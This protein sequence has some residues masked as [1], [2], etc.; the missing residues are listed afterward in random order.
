[1]TVSDPTLD[2]QLS[3]FL[4]DDLT[5]QE[6]HELEERLSTD[7]ELS[8][9]LES[10]RRL[11]L[12]IG[13]LAER[14]QPPAALDRLVA[15]RSL[16]START[17][18]RR[19][20]HALAAAATVVIAV[21]VGLQIA[22]RGG[23]GDHHDTA[24]QPRQA[25][26]PT[27]F[28][29]APLPE[30][31]DDGE[32]GPSARL[33]QTP[34]AQPQLDD[35]PALEPG[36][37]YDAPPT[38]EQRK[39]VATVD[40]PET[41]RKAHPSQEL[42][43]HASRLESIDPRAAD[44][45]DTPTTEGISQ[46]AAPR[47]AS[48]SRLRYAEEETTHDAPMATTEALSAVPQQLIRIQSVEL[49]FTDDDARRTVPVDIALTMAPGE[50]TEIDGLHPVDVTVDADGTITSVEPVSEPSAGLAA[51]LDAL[52][53]QRLEPLELPAGSHRARVKISSD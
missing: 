4:D 49:L 39:S 5:P 37:P 27:P 22:K 2:E 19:W 11:Q 32:L 7:P 29:L 1:M 23:L 20:L 9:R 52:R 47:P 6:R 50:P 17:A 8:A 15:P 53:G 30:G 45:R 13:A 25:A 12:A 42:Q 28:A 36:G 48:V 44:A 41:A 31:T 24:G 21:G 16:E 3:R 10:L 51:I 14:D 26:A 35:P 33:I 38:A 43:D 40:T 18:R 46:R 34:P